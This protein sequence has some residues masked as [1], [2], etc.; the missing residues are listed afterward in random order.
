MLHCVDCNVDDKYQSVCKPG[1]G[2]LRSDAS[3]FTV[4]SFH[5]VPASLTPPSPLSE[6]QYAKAGYV[7][8]ASLSKRH[9]NRVVEG[10][11]SQVSRLAT[12]TISAA[13]GPASHD[14]VCRELP[15]KLKTG[16]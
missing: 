13:V 16:E 2:A 14:G 8:P 3:S 12:S 5:A 10:L 4:G 11:R 6:A 7:T 9:V 1:G 15:L